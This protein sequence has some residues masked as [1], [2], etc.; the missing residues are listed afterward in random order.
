ME[1]RAHKK[2]HKV[3]P[4]FLEGVKLTPHNFNM[5]ENPVHGEIVHGQLRQ[6]LFRS[7]YYQ[8][9]DMEMPSMHSGEYMKLKSIEKIQ[10]KSDSPLE[11]YFQNKKVCENVKSLLKIE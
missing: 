2:H 3:P 9:S 8:I 4:A 11:S 6:D 10:C 5:P 1:D 7:T